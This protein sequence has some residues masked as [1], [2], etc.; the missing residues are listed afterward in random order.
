M[1]FANP[2]RSGRKPPEPLSGKRNELSDEAIM[3]EELRLA[4]TSEAEIQ[5]AVD[6][7]SEEARAKTLMGSKKKGSKA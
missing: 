7:S 5:H 6:V 3:R 1:K 2:A 4:G